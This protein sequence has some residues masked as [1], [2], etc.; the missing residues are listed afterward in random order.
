MSL[1]DAIEKLRSNGDLIEH[2][3][4]DQIGERLPGYVL[5]WAEYIG[6]DG[7]ANALPMSG[8]SDEES[9]SRGEYW[10]KLYTILESLVLSWNIEQSLI[11]LE[12]IDSFDT[13]TRNLNQWMAFHAH[14]GRIYD[15][16]KKISE[17]GEIKSSELLRPFAQ[18]WEERHI[19]LHGPKIPLKW[20]CSILCVPPLGKGERQWNDK[21]Q[22][23]DLRG[24]EYEFLAKT[25]SDTLRELEVR[26]DRCI[27]E[28][29][30]VLPRSL[31]WEPI[32]WPQPLAQ[33]G[34]PTDRANSET[35]PPLSLSGVA[36][37]PSGSAGHGII[38]NN[39]I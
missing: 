11:N 18:F 5:L 3:C 8:A 28:L 4:A 16:V 12:Q 22:W 19:A 25:V 29:R 9:K 34:K 23:A 17:R 24:D 27:S 30:K 36:P 14:L 38:L 32:V 31:G 33:I 20:V 7:H 37:P 6:N 13:Y 10:Q 21:K 15:M 35:I 39:G 26:L 1:A 2:H